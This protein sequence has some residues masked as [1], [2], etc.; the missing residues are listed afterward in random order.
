MDNY[1]LIELSV[2]KVEE[3]DLADY[4]EAK[5]KLFD[6]I[7]AEADGLL[8]IETYKSITALP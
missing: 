8:F 5:E 6:K 1:G 7:T 4:I 2:V 3:D